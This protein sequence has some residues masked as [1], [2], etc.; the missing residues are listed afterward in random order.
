MLKWQKFFIHSFLKWLTLCY[1]FL[2]FIA[3]CRYFIVTIYNSIQNLISWSIN[4][5]II[6][7]INILL[8]IKWVAL[9]YAIHLVGFGASAAVLRWKY[10]ESNVDSFYFILF[11]YFPIYSL[12]DI[13]VTDQFEIQYSKLTSFLL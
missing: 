12:K 11:I 1:Y 4:I 5:I 7:I 13:L 3:N 6:I 2:G 9:F 8:I 10:I